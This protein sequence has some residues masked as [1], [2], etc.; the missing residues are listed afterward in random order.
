VSARHVLLCAFLASAFGQQSAI[1]FDGDEA[2]LRVA[3][4]HFAAWQDSQR[5]LSHAVVA[6][7]N[8][9]A[10]VA[11]NPALRDELLRMAED[12]QAVRRDL[13]P[14]PDDAQIGKLLKV[15]ALNLQR[16]KA[17]VQRWGFPLNT[18][19]GDD[20]VAAAFILVQHASDHH[21]QAQVLRQLAPRVKT[22]LIGAD[23]FALLTDRVL[24]D[25]GKL[26]LYG[27]QLKGVEGGQLTLAPIEAPREVDQRRAAL[28]MPP[29]EDYLCVVKAAYAAPSAK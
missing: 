27:T 22:G 17:I 10:P 6:R 14:N 5:A 28:G 1:G 20:G 4:P 9:L 25:Q 23:Q 12:D 24:V 13:P 26:Q 2:R 19:V 18:L 21:F 8:L 7:E 16:I 29:L 11:S 15:D 3:C